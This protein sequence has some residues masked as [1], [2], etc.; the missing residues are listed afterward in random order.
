MLEYICDI[1]KTC[2][3]LN[4][5]QIYIY[6]NKYNLPTD[7]RVFVCV[8]L[9]HSKIFSASREQVTTVNGYADRISVNIQSSV[10]VNIYARTYE[11]VQR[12]YEVITALNSSYSQGIQERYGFHIARIPST[13][14]N[15]SGIDG[16]AIPYR[17]QITFNVLSKEIKEI[18]ADYYNQFTNEV[19][20]EEVGN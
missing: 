14:N 6:N 1:I 5:D 7:S 9:E 3:R 20:Q 12:Q 16:A 4:D 11:A 2:M 13:F 8:G 17:F 18:L 19:L 15:I 10:S